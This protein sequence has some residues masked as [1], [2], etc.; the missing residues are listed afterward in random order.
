M[1]FQKSSLYGCKKR[2]TA[3]L[4]AGLIITQSGCGNNAP[5][6]NVS[7]DEDYLLNTYCTVTIYEAGRE[8]LIREAFTY[9]RQLENLLSRTVADSEVAAVNRSTAGEAVSVSLETA[10]VVERGLYYSALSGGLFDITLGALTELWNFSSNDPR[11]P[12]QADIEQALTSADYQTIGI[13]WAAGRGSAAITKANLDTHIDLGGIAKGYIA[14][15]VK[16]FLENRGVS[17]ALINF[18]G[19]VVVLGAKEDGAPWVIGV[20]KPFSAEEEGDL[21]RELSGEIVVTHGS[22]V[23]SGIYERKFTENGQLYYHILD[24]ETGYPRETDL[25]SVTVIGPASTDCDALS[26]ICLMLGLEEGQ[27]LIE[28]MEPYEAVFIP[29]VGGIAVTDGARFTSYEGSEGTQ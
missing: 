27:A 25:I 6:T 15:C 28:G 18:G 24:P 29:K 7:W 4:I 8:E 10:D 5:S 1:T 26:T 9:A 11:V 21:V 22:V 13:S 17:S 12:A 19:N 16:D 23:T 3:L 14:D 2:L 20:E